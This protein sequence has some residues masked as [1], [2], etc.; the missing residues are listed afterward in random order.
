MN[1]PCIIVRLS[2]STM[3]NLVNY[4]CTSNKFVWF[5]K[6]EG[7]IGRANKIKKSYLYLQNTY[8]TI[9]NALFTEIR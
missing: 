9:D 5:Y 3:N 4:G 6:D 8:F 1:E 7:K 2:S